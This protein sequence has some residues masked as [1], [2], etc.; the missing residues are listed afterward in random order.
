MSLLNMLGTS[1]W[2]TRLTKESDDR[3]DEGQRGGTE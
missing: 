2:K 1:T 3:G